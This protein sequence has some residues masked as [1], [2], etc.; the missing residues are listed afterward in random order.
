MRRRMKFSLVV[1]IPPFSHLNTPKSILVTTPYKTTTPPSPRN[2][3]H[4]K[5]KADL[6]HTINHTSIVVEPFQISP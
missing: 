3:W 1:S 6:Y 2:T 4:S 5:N